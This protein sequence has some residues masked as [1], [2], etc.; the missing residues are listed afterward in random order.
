[1]CVCSRVLSNNQL[2][3]FPLVVFNLSSLQLLTLD[4]NPLTTPAFTAEQFTFL[5]KVASLKL[6]NAT[7]SV[8]ETDVCPSPDVIEKLSAFFTFCNSSRGSSS[9]GSVDLAA[10]TPLASPTSVSPAVQTGENAIDGS[11]SSTTWVV[12][13]AV[14][15]GVVL[16][17]I[18]FVLYRKRQRDESPKLANS[19]MPSIA[20]GMGDLADHPYMELHA[21]SSC[22]QTT[23]DF[24]LLANVADGYIALTR[25]SYNDVFLHRMIRVSS[26]SE[27]WFGEFL[28]APVII[29]KMKSNAASKAVLREFV[30]EIEHMA[31]LS[32]ARIAAFK[33]AMWDTEGT[34]LCAVVEFVEHGALRDCIAR[35]VSLSTTQ[36]LAI[37]RQVVDAMVFLHQK[38]IVHGRL[39]SFNVLLDA[40]YGA[41]LSLFAIFHYVKLSPLDFECGVFA[42]PEVLRGGQSTEKADV[43]SLGVVLVELDTGE[44]PVINAR[45]SLTTGA[46]LSP[47]PAHGFRLSA[48]C[49]PIMREVIAACLERDPARRPTMAEVAVALKTG[50]FA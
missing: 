9:S 8:I 24:E 28:D 17:A 48:T 46:S 19:S 23:S 25:L 22:S 4:S 34:E 13:G 14:A 50:A 40:H 6:S 12:L 15:G 33:G 18:A 29:K 7:G 42:A 5:S 21:P 47:P 35:P 26:R 30:T 44:N 32:H 38:R 10:L 41:K 45:R 36:Q 49:S 31:E 1:M 2:H 37:A 39:S 43:Y 11:S 3:E 16:L 20:I 27:L